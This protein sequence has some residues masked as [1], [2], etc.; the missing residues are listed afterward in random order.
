MAMTR[1]GLPVVRD[2]TIEGLTTY[3][4]PFPPSDRAEWKNDDLEHTCDLYDENIEEWR[5]L[6]A[7]V[8]GVKALLN[9]GVIERNERESPE[10]FKR[11]SSEMYGFDYSRAIVELFT[12]YLFQRPV[13]RDLGSLQSDPLWTLFTEDCDLNG[14]RYDDWLTSVSQEAGTFGHVGIVV[15]KPSVPVR[16]VADAKKLEI[17]PYL[18]LYTPPSILDWAY[19]RDEYGRSRLVYLKL[20]DDD[21]T[22]R[23]WWRDKWEAWRKGEGSGE[24]GEKIGEGPNALGEIPFVW[25][26]NDRPRKVGLGR[27]DVAGVARVDVSIIRNLSE[28]EEIIGYAAFPMLRKPMA[29]VGSQDGVDDVGV[30]AVIEFD[31]EL[32]EAGKADWLPAEVAG[33]MDA[34]MT[35]VR[36][37][38]AEIYRASNAGGMA[39]TEINAE[40]QSGVA[41]Q[42]QFQLLNSKLCKKAVGLEQAEEDVVRLWKA[43]QGQDAIESIEISRSRKYDVENLAMD[44]ENYM[45]SSTIVDSTTFDQSVQKIVARR[46]LPT[47]P[48]ELLDE[49]DAEIEEG[50]VKPTTMEE[51]A[52]QSRPAKRP[53]EAPPGQDDAME[54][55]A[56]EGE[57]PAETGEE[58]E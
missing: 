11:R 21:G 49:I 46:V 26:Y 52:A 24:M 43:W 22:Y 30:S 47:A 28:G 58:T 15:D 55:S 38:V 2:A 57:E 4:L 54:G 39:A 32:G 17:Y 50:P 31:P 9:L 1:R 44:L 35:W 14:S 6:D 16:T 45:T 41:I 27:S 53:D 5:L 29:R 51:I 25:L 12:H 56:P 7:A 40:A 10:N 36:L 13:H 8:E 33:P 20:K 37:K 23:L 42:A 48:D 34:I 18:C 19:E 3:R